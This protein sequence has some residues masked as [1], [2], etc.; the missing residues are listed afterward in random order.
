MSTNG[1][2]AHN[3]YLHMRQVSQQFKALYESV[4]TVLLFL[5]ETSDVQHVISEYTILFYN[6]LVP[7]ATYFKFVLS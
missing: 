4:N 7:N 5:N 1:K 3:R 6:H 2:Q